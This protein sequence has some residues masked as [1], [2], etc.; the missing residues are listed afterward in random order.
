MVFLS[1]SFVFFSVIRLYCNEAVGE[2]E[3]NYVFKMS[4]IP[5]W[6][7]AFFPPMWRWETQL[8]NGPY[9]SPQGW[10]LNVI[11]DWGPVWKIWSEKVHLFMERT[12]WSGSAIAHHLHVANSDPNQL[13]SCVI[14]PFFSFLSIGTLYLAHLG[15]SFKSSFRIQEPKWSLLLLLRSKV[16][17]QHYQQQLQ[18][19][20]FLQLLSVAISLCSLWLIKT[21]LNAPR[22]PEFTIIS[23]YAL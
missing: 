12:V 19:P 1:S 4:S 17:R 21:A 5:L 7:A 14:P 16:E 23:N 8:G 18:Q 10:L 13:E 9:Y 3:G 2:E 11:A 6:K 22:S 20:L 15:S